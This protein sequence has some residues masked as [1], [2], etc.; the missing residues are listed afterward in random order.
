MGQCLRAHEKAFPLESPSKPVPPS[1][2]RG[3]L[4][5]TPP[6]PPLHSSPPFPLRG[7]GQGWARPGVHRA[8]PERSES[9]GGQSE[10]RAKRG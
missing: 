2:G 1:G 3:L 5:K 4:Q 6:P 10:P 9:T 7:H 8:S